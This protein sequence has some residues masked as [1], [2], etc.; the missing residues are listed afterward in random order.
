[1]PKPKILVIDDEEEMLKSC[2]TL[3]AA[4]E[5]GGIFLKDP[6]LAVETVIRERP[7]VALIDLKMPGTDG[8]KVMKDILLAAPDLLTIVFTAY[9]S[10]DTAVQA[11]QAGAHDYIPKPFSAE[12]LKLSI[13]R[14]LRLKSLERKNRALSEKVV[15]LGKFKPLVGASRAM[16][17]VFALLQKVAQSTANVLILGE[18]GTGKELAARALHATGP[19][20]NKPF[21]AIDCASIPE[22]LLQAELFG[23]EKG[24]YTDAHSAKPGLLETAHGG[25]L[26]LDEIGDLPFPLQAKL[27]RVLQEKR[28]RRL[29]SNEEIQVDFRTVSAT[30]H[31]LR[32]LI[33]EGRFREDLYFRLNV[34]EVALPPLRDKREDIVPLARHFLK[35]LSAGGPGKSLSPAVL[36]LLERYRWPGNVRE[37]QNVLEHACVLAEG[38]II[39]VDDLPEKLKAGAPTLVPEGSIG[40]SEAGTLFERNF[41]RDA[42]DRNRWDLKETARHCKVSVRTLQRYIRALNLRP[43]GQT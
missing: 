25:T 27:L 8:I 17:K 34:I 3:F 2:E 15:E 9:A 43:P 39:E 14:G 6:A 32:A 33:R 11:M 29:G 1:M 21:V 30:N 20:A 4:W 38:G 42:L 13:E 37:L 36:S 40:F 31:D 35:K 7:E 24:A 19:R 41:F 10:L 23:H 28:F 12:H 22:T 18:S 26:F 5:F 16:R